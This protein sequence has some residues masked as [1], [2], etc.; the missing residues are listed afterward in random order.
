MPSPSG[1]FHPAKHFRQRH[2]QA[3]HA[4][5]HADETASSPVPNLAGIP[6]GK[7][8]LVT[9]D[10]QLTALVSQL[11][12]QKSF[13]YD[14]EFIG[15]MTYRPQLCLIQVGTVD[16]VALIDPLAGV[17]L[18]P[19]WELLCDAS[20]RKL[21]HAGD[22]DLEHVW[23]AT[24]RAPANVL[25]TQVAGGFVALSY[26]AALTKL[27]QEFTGTKLHK[28]FTFTDWSHR[29]LS[30][31]QLRYAADDVRYLPLL[32]GK[33]EAM[34]RERGRYDWAMA[35][36]DARCL[37]SKPSTDPR[38]AWQRV[39]GNA[40]LDARGLRI[41][42]ELAAWREDAAKNADVPSRTFVKDEVLVDLSRHPPKSID[43]IANIKH[44]PRPV[45]EHHGQTI[46]DTIARAIE[47]KSGPT[48]ADSQSEPLLSDKFR[49]DS[50]WAAAQS[51][52]AGQGLDASLVTSRQEI[53][54]LDRAIQSKQSFDDLRLMSTWRRAAVGEKLLKL[55]AG[56]RV[57]LSWSDD[58]LSLDA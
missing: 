47:A 57:T 41:L 51:I 52:A 32:A 16:R 19:F 7:A 26:P 56:A 43:R 4:S 34:L 46:L 54:D 1:N 58:S 23:R 21:V 36:C 49:H 14:T 20:I 35:E 5:A 45:V 30:S 53:V 44:M 13:A 22:Q 9:D 27:V 25:D 11:V 42:Q 2:R 18:A 15:E 3:Q 12:Q 50:L 38:E 8:E 33:L 29:P 40:S 24:G 28:A 17:D 6:Q 31:S 48:P 39:R 37:L 55:I 10:A